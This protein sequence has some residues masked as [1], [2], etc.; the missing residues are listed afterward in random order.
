M[1]KLFVIPFLV[2][3]ASQVQAVEPL[4]NNSLEN[5]LEDDEINYKI[6]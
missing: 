4:K 5:I 6:L 3:I 1:K 2:L